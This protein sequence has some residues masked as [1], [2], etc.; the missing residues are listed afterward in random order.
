MFSSIRLGLAA[1]IMYVENLFVSEQY[2]RLGV[3]VALMQEAKNVCKKNSCLNMKWE[4]ESD[5]ENAIAFYKKSGA[6]V[7]FRGIGSF[8]LR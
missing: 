5:N 4:V 6:T 2:R 7:S 1:K 3:G 8:N